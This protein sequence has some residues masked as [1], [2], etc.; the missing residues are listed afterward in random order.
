M[1]GAY[2]VHAREG[3]ASR[4][5]TPLSCLP[6]SVTV[7]AARAQSSCIASVGSDMDAYARWS[8]TLD[9]WMSHAEFDMA[10]FNRLCRVYNLD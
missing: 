1:G 9:K 8:A 4:Q 5:M 10:E 7:M 6:T 2:L 3:T